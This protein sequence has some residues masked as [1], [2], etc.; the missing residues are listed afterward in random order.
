[1]SERILGRYLLGEE[2]GRGGMSVVYRARDPVLE[3]DV[4][5]KVLHP[6]LAD[7]ADARARFTREAKAI[8]RLKHR[9]IVEIFDF[10]PPDCDEAYIVTELI[11][12]PTL[13]EFMRDHPIQ[14]SE[15]AALI[16]RPIFE[17]LEIA[18]RN[19]IVH[20]DVKPENIMIRPDGTLVLMDFGI[21]QMVDMETLTATGTML[22]SPA[23]MAPEVVEGASVGLAADLFSAGTVLYWLVCGALPFTGPNPAALFR[24]IVECR[25]DPVL[26]R[27]PKAGRGIARITERCLAQAPQDR[28]ASAGEVA[29]ELTALLRTA[30]F[31]RLQEAQLHLTRDPEVYQDLLPR[32]MIPAYFNAAEVAHRAGET[33]KALN[34][35]SRLLSLDKAH[36]EGL[37][38]LRLIE[39]GHRRRYFYL[40]AMASM[41]IGCLGVGLWVGLAAPAFNAHLEID[42]TPP[43]HAHTSGLDASLAPP[44][45]DA[46][47]D[48][49]D[50]LDLPWMDMAHDAASPRL[51]R[52]PRWMKPHKRAVKRASSRHDAGLNKPP[53]QLI[54]LKI[55][56]SFK[57]AWI[58]INGKK[59]GYIAGNE[60]GKI[61]LPV[62]RHVVEFR[63]VHCEQNIQRIHLKPGQKERIIEFQ[64]DFKPAFVRF[65]ARSKIPVRNARGDVLGL[66]NQNIPITMKQ[67]QEE[68]SFLIGDSARGFQAQTV[69]LRAGKTTVIQ[70][71]TVSPN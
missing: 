42:A 62:G 4:A 38:L 27:A 65:H 56:S 61:K 60:N 49:G 68:I 71:V 66:T 28:P 67:T 25:F 36:A 58:Y 3:R 26:Q 53:P 64:C 59:T 52:R 13:R 9:Y 6:H 70:H 57:G 43:I 1:M 63:S 15:V 11:E 12:G 47:L 22:G 34:Y 29:Q 23:H 69:G 40:P 48:G 39:S 45:I 46:A 41:L 20:R 21:A 17:A 32:Q 37:R 55:A 5:V 2:L 10:A 14:H 54:P 19:G 44:S 50:L 8:A 35:L 16:M 30:G 51:V 18:H 24:R 7:R 31:E 33:A